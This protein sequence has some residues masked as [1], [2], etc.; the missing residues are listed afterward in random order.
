[1]GTKNKRVQVALSDEATKLVD[2]L[3][4]LT[5]QSKSSVV[6]E[7]MDVA[8][9]AIQTTIEA[10]R[11]LQEQPREAQRLL[12]NFT[13]EAIVMASQASLD[14]DAAIDSRTVKGKRRKGGLS[15]RATK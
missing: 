10:V 12:A 8:L 4:A 11:L 5:G 13:N 3:S 14:L 15:G 7:M 9:P 6:S 1:M 2:E